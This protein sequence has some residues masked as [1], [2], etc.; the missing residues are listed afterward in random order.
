MKDSFVLH[1]DSLRVLDKLSDEQAGKLFKAI[2][3]YHLGNSYDLD[4]ALEMAFLPFENQFERDKIAYEKVCNRN[5]TNGSKGGRPRKPKETEKTQVVLD[6]PKKADSDS[7]SDSVNDNEI[8]NTV[9]SIDFDHLLEFFKTKLKR[10]F[11]TINQSVKKKYK[12]RLKEGYTKEDILSAVNNAVKSD[13]HKDNNFQYLT[14]E[15]FSRSNTLDKYSKVTESKTSDLSDLKKSIDRLVWN[16][17]KSSGNDAI[18]SLCS[19]YSIT[20]QQFLELYE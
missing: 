20:K 3:A 10:P 7:D 6:K 19:K 9:E 13:Y 5:K 8:K 17:T 2:K 16:V 12:A 18:N 1:N 4:F 14:P 15:F 11:R